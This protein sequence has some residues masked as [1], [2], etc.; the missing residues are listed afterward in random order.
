MLLSRS[1]L[2]LRRER[3]KSTM[4]VAVSL[5]QAVPASLSGSVS[6]LRSEFKPLWEAILEDNLDSFRRQ[7]REL[8]REGQIEI[9]QVRNEGETLLHVAC[10]IAAADIVAMLLH[11]MGE[12][13]IKSDRREE[14]LWLLDIEKRWTPLHY[15]CRQQRA[16][17]VKQLLYPPWP[18][19]DGI[20][21]RTCPQTIPSTVTT[22]LLSTETTLEIMRLLLQHSRGNP[23]YGFND[24][25]A[26]FPSCRLPKSSLEHAVPIVVLG[27]KNSGK[28]TIIKS[29]QIEGAGTRLLY[30]FK[31]VSGAAQ[32]RGGVIPTQV[33]E[34]NYLGKVVFFELSGNREFVHEAILELGHLADAVFIMVIDTREEI[35]VMIQ[36]MVYW[37]DFIRQHA[38][39]RADDTTLQPNIII[40]GS[41]RDVLPFGRML[42]PNERFLIAYS[43]AQAAFQNCN[44]LSLHTMDF[45]RAT[46]Q[47]LVI[48]YKLYYLLQ[49]LRQNR[50]PL[51]SIS[52]VLYSVINDLCG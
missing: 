9:V 45:R 12:P 22:T 15:A 31:N 25:N 29:L 33:E 50:P 34:H 46:L 13:E 37:A 17:I 44:V 26:R 47:I 2:M 23:L 18:N 51:P 3:F 27:E 16:D 11:T 42:A 21:A 10:D 4:A 38:H 6:T 32:H 39:Y 28:S 14:L 19:G 48:Q 5:P 40:I 49:K 41:H 43:R 35:P 52:Y 8:S 7:F 24:F 20:R 36:Q 30:L 1:V